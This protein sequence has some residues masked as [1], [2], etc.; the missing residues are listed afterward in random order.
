MQY[1][2]FDL[3][4]IDPDTMLITNAVTPEGAKQNYA[5]EVGIKEQW[6]QED[7]YDRSVNMSFA[8]R[9]FLQSEVELDRFSKDGTIL[10]DDA[11]FERRVRRFF[12]SRPPWARLYLSMWND[13]ETP[14]DMLHVSHPFPDLM[15]I[16]MYLNYDSN[17]DGLTV[18]PTQHL[19]RR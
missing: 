19:K 12:G 16:F 10:I 14:Q 4:N 5:F 15:L 8:E 2:V 11:E 3:N 1:L 6:F 18:I 13:Q 9:F 17:G 7:V